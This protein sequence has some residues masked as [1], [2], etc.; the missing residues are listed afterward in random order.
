M[1]ENCDKLTSQTHGTFRTITYHGSTNNDLTGSEKE[2]EKVDVFCNNRDLF[3]IV[4]I[5]YKLVKKQTLKGNKVLSASKHYY[6]TNTL[7]IF[8]IGW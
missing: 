1:V 8:D 7:S 6:T 3:N 4:N 5:I 2:S